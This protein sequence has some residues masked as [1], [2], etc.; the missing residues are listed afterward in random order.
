MTNLTF[1]SS[2]FRCEDDLYNGIAEMYV[3]GDTKKNPVEFIDSLDIR[4]FVGGPDGDLYDEDPIR[5]AYGNPLDLMDVVE[6]V[7][8]RLVLA[9]DA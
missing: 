1:G 9:R 2:L 5:D 4:D 7:K 3:G 8:T 6:E